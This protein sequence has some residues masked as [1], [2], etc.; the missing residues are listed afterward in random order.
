LLVPAQNL[1]EALKQLKP[2]IESARKTVP[3]LELPVLIGFVAP[4]LARVFQVS[5]EVITKRL[6]AEGISPV[7][8]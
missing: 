3:D 7:Q 8:E 2:L 6:E 4:K 1:S 5:A